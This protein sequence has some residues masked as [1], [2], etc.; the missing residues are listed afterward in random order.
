MRGRGVLA[1][2]VALVLNQAVA[3]QEQRLAVPSFRSAS[4][5]VVLP[6]TVTDREGGFVSGLPR[7]RFAV[8]DN[9][10]TQDI[11][12]FSNDDTPV[13]VALVLDN[14]GSMRGK[15]ADVIIA[16]LAFARSSNPDDE[17][18]AI[19]F[20]DRVRDALDG[21]SL[22]ASEQSEL[23]QALRTLA[24][25]G[26]T[27][28]YDAL[29]SGLNRLDSGAHRRKVLVLL[30]DGGDNASRMATLDDVVEQAQRADVT[31]FT[32]GMFDDG[33]AET[34][35]G[36]LKRLADATGGE[37]LLPKSAGVLLK[38]CERIALAIRTSYIIGFAPPARDGGYHRVQVKVDGR[39]GRRLTARTRQGYVAGKD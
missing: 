7:E 11:T 19:E 38:A 4:E 22:A 31:I 23:E 37:R 29:S 34:N 14:S 36:V 8:L 33:A 27:A 1:L 13:S 5:Q 9:G 35:P 17:L 20:N 15:L 25:A 24:P 21:R 18:F 28:L 6:V 3:A 39:D 32:I 16:T 30:S 10:R 26:Q 2:L 12:L